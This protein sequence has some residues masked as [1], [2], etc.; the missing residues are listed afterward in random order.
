VRGIAGRGGN[1]A[2]RV[3]LALAV[4]VAL[5]GCEQTLLPPEEGE[6]RGGVERARPGARLA[7]QP[8]PEPVVEDPPFD[9]TDELV[10]DFC[11]PEDVPDYRVA[12]AE[13]VGNEHLGAPRNA[14]KRSSRPREGERAGPWRGWG[15]RCPCAGP[16]VVSKPIGRICRRRPA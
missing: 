3:L 14:R 1:A 10:G 2:V 15:C 8:A 9:A 12:S 4:F 7:P 6:E 5:S 13:G 16:K 11:R